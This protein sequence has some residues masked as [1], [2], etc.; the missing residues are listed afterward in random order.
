MLISWQIKA[1]IALVAVLGAAYAGHWLTNNHWSTKWA[2]H[3]AADA[4]EHAKAAN[5][6]LTKQNELTAKLDKVQTDAKIQQAKLKA[7]ADNLSA[8]ADSL[9]KQ[10]TMSEA[11]ST[12]ATAAIT[13][14]RRAAATDTAVQS[15]L[16]NWSIST[17]AE[18]ARVA[19]DSRSRGLACEKAYNLAR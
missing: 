9:R 18:L 4:L 7:D 15:E 19:D 8:T 12:D 13:K 10:L 11:A 3:I 5:D 1:A 6:A 16:L 17:N 2:E 14:L